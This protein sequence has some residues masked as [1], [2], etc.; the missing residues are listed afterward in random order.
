M[1]NVTTSTFFLCLMLLAG[2]LFAQQSAVEENAVAEPKGKISFEIPRY[3]FGQIEQ[4][5][6]VT[7][8]FEFVNT[9]N[10]PVIISNV[11]AT[12]G[13]TVPQWSREPVAPGQKGIVSATFNSSGKMG[14]Q[15]KPITIFSNAENQQERIYLIG[16]VVP[17]TK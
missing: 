2:S 6:K 12:C 10:A 13:C 17:V 5:E 1:K 9:G 11:Q 8:K 7:Y 3:E 16:S 15:V 4:G 14:R